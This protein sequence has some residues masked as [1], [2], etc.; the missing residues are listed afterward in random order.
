[1]VPGILFFQFLT[2][3]SDIRRIKEN[4]NLLFELFKKPNNKF[5]LSYTILSSTSV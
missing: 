5:I 4:W 3:E 2:H 1:M